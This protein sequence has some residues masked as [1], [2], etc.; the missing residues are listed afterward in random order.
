MTST[1]K[2]GLNEPCNEQGGSL[3]GGGTYSCN[4]GLICNFAVGLPTPTCQNPNSNDAGGPCSSDQNCATG[5]FCSAAVGGSVCNAE[6]LQGSPCPSGFGCA[7]GLM[8][9]KFLD[10]GTT[11]CEPEGGTATVTEGEAGSNAESAE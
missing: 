1:S 8:C 11:A 6:I 3:V 4:A 2:G 5:L 7:M 9:V 10:A